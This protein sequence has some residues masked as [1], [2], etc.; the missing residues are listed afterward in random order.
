MRLATAIDV[1]PTY[2]AIATVAFTGERRFVWQFGE[3]VEFR[4]GYRLIGGTEVPLIGRDTVA[5]ILADTAQ[6]GGLV[7]I[8]RADRVFPS[9]DMARL[10]NQVQRLM[11]TTR[12][13]GKLIDLA[14][15]LGL[16]PTTSAATQWR[17]AL[18]RK[19]SPQ[20]HEIAAVIETLVAGAPTHLPLAKTQHLYD[21]AGLAVV[22]LAIDA[23][24]QLPLD[25]PPSVLAALHRAR[26]NQQISAAS[27]KLEKGGATVLT[28]GQRDRKRDAAR[29][30]ARTRATKT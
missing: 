8:E 16:T 27:R 21:A 24:Y 10:L 20:D 4:G 22:L 3:I 29:R 13:E 28:K 15:G 18:V 30:A 5:A 11:E 14:N 12:I 9:E 7:G 26:V 2:S 25:L 17:E 6:A 19:Q 1:G 23:G